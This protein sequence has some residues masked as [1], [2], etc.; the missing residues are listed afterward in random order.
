MEAAPA[1]LLEAVSVSVA[2]WIRAHLVRLAA[3]RMM[4]DE[5]E[6]LVSQVAARA[7]DDLGA[8]LSTDVDAQRA[9]PLHVLR[10]AAGVATAALRSAGVPPA[11]RDAVETEA[12]PDDDYAIGPLTWRDLSEDVHEA[13]ITW[14]AWKAATIISRRRAEGRT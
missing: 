1:A 12:M 2:P 11:P 10:S 5:I 13:G 9:N 14:G 8:L 4:N 6:A 7:I 3:D